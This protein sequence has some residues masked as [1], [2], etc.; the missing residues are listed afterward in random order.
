MAERRSRQHYNGRID[1]PA[2]PDSLNRTNETKQLKIEVIDHA[3]STR[4]VRVPVVTGPKGVYMCVFVTSYM[5][6]NTQL[7]FISSWLGDTASM[8]LERSF[9]YS[10]RL[11]SSRVWF[12]YLIQ[13]H[14]TMIRSTAQTRRTFGTIATV[15][16]HRSAVSI[17]GTHLCATVMLKYFL[18]AR[19]YERERDIFVWWQQSECNARFTWQ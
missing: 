16:L 12:W 17:T 3:H 5:C 11:P 6:R 19:R 14:L 9:V 10:R 18:L 4:S 13:F 15:R 8:T 2:R 7:L 1:S